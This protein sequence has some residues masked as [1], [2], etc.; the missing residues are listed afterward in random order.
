MQHTPGASAIGVELGSSTVTVSIRRGEQETDIRRLDGDAPLETVLERVREARDEAAGAAPVGFAVP[1][2]WGAARRQELVYLAGEA[3]LGE[4]EVMAAPEA[5]AICYVKGLGRELATGSGLAVCDLGARTFDVAVV[6]RGEEDF[7]HRGS[8]STAEVGGREF[9]QLLFAY[10]S[11]RYRDTDPEFWDTVGAPADLDEEVLRASLLDEI[12]AAR[13]LISKRPRAGVPL[14]IG[15]RDLH[16]TRDE[17]ESCIGELL[18]QS[19]DLVAAAIAE[20]D[21]PVTGLILV[22][23]ASRTPLLATVLAE[24]TG[25]EPVVPAYPEAAAADGAR[26]VALANAPAAAESR[27]R[28]RTMRRVGVLAAVLVPLVAAGAVYGNQ[29]GGDAQPEASASETPDGSATAATSEAATTEDVEGGSGAGGQEAPGSPHAAATSE[30]AEEETSEA[31]TEESEAP[32]SG[33]VPDVAGMTAADAVQALGGAGFAE[34]AREGEQEGLFGPYYDDCEV[35]GQSPAAGQEA[36]FDDTVTITYSYS[37]SDP[38][39]CD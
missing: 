32:T 25:L 23:G 12:R 35:I 13:E 8:T 38:S 21:V 14:P 39:V 27:P 3:G 16:L 28:G 19:A 31:S 26:I 6:V 29:L 15:E 11:G 5:A 2:S 24:R 10:L 22:G 7:Q 37:G 4:V 9:D 18:L 1:A 20:S 33:T 30:A 36:D 34:V 17:V